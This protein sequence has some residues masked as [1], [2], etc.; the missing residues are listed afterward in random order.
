MK[1]SI[2]ASFVDTVM[3]DHL[4]NILLVAEMG[5][6]IH[7]LDFRLVIDSLKKYYL[8]SF[9]HHQETVLECHHHR[10]MRMSLNLRRFLL[11]VFTSSTGD[12]E[13]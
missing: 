2:D 7:T 8:N 3:H 6:A 5:A 1:G 9:L 10:L 12:T 11:E 13:G 4:G